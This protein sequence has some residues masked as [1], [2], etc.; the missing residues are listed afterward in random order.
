MPGSVVSTRSSLSA[1]SSLP[2]ATTTIPAWIE[3]PMPTPPPWCTLTQVAPAATLTSAFRIGQSAIASEPSRIASVSRYG[4]ATEPES[5]WSRPITTGADTAPE[6]TSSLIASPAFARSPVAEPADPRRQ[7][8]EG[9]ASRSELE[10]ALEERVVREQ[11]RELAVDRVDVRRV[12]REHRPPK[13]P[14]PT[15]EERPDVRR[16]EAR[17]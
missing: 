8:L 14:D 15:A 9:D 3:L 7:A 10:P 11:G 13:R 17:I 2:S 16:D 5:R 4:D 6:R 12:A 1:A